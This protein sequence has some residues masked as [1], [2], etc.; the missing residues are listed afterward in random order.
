[1]DKKKVLMLCP[2]FF[3]YQKVIA[4]GSAGAGL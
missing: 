4:E 3:G 2:T 1:M